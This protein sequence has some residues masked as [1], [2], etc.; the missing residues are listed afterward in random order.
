MVTSKHVLVTLH[1]LTLALAC[2]EP[3]DAGPGSE[4]TASDETAQAPTTGAGGEVSSTGAHDTGTHDTGAHDT[5]AHDTGTHDTG[6][7]ESTG[8]GPPPDP[9]SCL[10]GGPTPVLP[11]GV[12]F[13]DVLAP[14]GQEPVT[15]ACSPLVRFAS[16]LLHPAFAAAHPKL[17]NGIT[18]TYVYRSEDGALVMI[19]GGWGLWVS[20]VVD[21]VPQVEDNLDARARL[22]AAIDALAPARGLA[23]IEFVVF[24]HGHPDHTG[25]AVMVQE[26]KN[27]PL[28]LWVGSGDVPML[29]DVL[30]EVPTGAA[31]KS[32]ADWVDAGHGVTLI[33]APSHTPGS[34][35]VCLPELGATISGGHLDPDDAGTSGNCSNG[36]DASGCPVACD[37]YAASLLAF[38]PGAYELHVHPLAYSE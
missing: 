38:P 25:Q 32:E 8:D 18:F 17:T 13:I 3:G 35:I 9:V 26:A 27:A 22:E 2:K 16:S 28:D 14:V 23:D 21:G 6:T 36:M 29:T 31:A 15:A 4:S 19:D 5:G 33:P 7:H 37:I 30:H 24:E 12:S 11:E 34:M 1:A 20:G 10:D